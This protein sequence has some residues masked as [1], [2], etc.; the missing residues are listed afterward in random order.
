MGKRIAQGR[1]CGA[2]EQPSIARMT[3]R[4]HKIGRRSHFCGDKPRCLGY[5]DRDL[6][7][8]GITWVERRCR[9]CGRR[10]PLPGR[11]RAGPSAKE[12][13]TGAHQP[14]SLSEAS[15]SAS[16]VAVFAVTTVTAS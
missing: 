3:G 9:T 16:F 2:K 5:G 11:R 6:R 1:Q 10:V 12:D 8:A 7:A 13:R 14:W 4:S 15:A